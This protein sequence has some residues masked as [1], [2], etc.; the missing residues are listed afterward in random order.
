VASTSTSVPI[1]LVNNVVLVQATLNTKHGVTLLL[2]TGA[3]VTILTPATARRIGLTPRDD[4][5]RRR[6][7]IVGGSEIEFA[8]VRLAALQIG[9]A[10][11]DEIEVGVYD[12]APESPIV[13]GILGGDFLS[14]FTLTL[15]RDARQ[16][17]L[18]AEVLGQR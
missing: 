13:D 4:G 3:E 18:E 1:Q 5:P 8:V 9:E 6:L 14:R 2:D 10:R 17:R 11:V 16:L 12:V 7:T 15:N